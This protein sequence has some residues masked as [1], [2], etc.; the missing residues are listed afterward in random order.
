MTDIKLWKILSNETTGWHEI[1]EASCRK[2]TKEQCSVRLEQLMNEG[3][4]PKYLKAVPD[5]D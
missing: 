1:E 5:N 2:L 4:N 3:Y